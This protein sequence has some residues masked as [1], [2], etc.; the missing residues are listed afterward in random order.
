M[1]TSIDSSQFRQIMSR[2]VTGVTVVTSRSGQDIHGLTCN[3]FCSI[4]VKPCTVMV[5]VAK[6]TRSWPLIEKSQIF[7]VNILSQTQS[8]ISDRF[9]GRHKD[10][11]NN[12]FEGISWTTDITGAPI[13]KGTQAYL[14][15]QLTQSFDGGTHT[16]FLGEVVALNLDDTKSPLVFFSSSYLGIDKLK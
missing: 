11:E 6:D 5:S 9:S 14:D 4:T 13:L 16:L 2:F 3:A 10:K 15:C 8:E 12:R 1:Q 7:A